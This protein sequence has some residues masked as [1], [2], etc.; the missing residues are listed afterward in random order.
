MSLYKTAVTATMMRLHG[1]SAVGLQFNSWDLVS[2]VAAFCIH[3]GPKGQRYCLLDFVAGHERAFAL[4]TMRVLSRKFLTTKKLD[5]NVD[6][7]AAAA[8]AAAATAMPVDDDVTAETDVAATVST[9]IKDGR[10]KMRA[11]RD[12]APLSPA[13]AGQE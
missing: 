4:T 13:S 11:S 2:M 9:P 7:V 6:V 1:S 3:Y 12:P 10:T 5:S 8:A